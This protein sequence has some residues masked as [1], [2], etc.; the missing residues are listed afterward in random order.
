MGKDLFYW[1][2]TLL[3][4]SKKGLNK[5]DVLNKAKKNETIFLNHLNKI[6]YN[7]ITNAEHMVNKFSQN[8]DL[9]DFYDK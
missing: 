9:S 2:S 5:R 3:N 4:L 1:A 6:I 7:K 8:E